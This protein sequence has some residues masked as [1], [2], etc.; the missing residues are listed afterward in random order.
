M[1]TVD[2]QWFLYKQFQIM[3]QKCTSVTMKGVWF[4]RGS[5][6][7]PSSKEEVAPHMGSASEQ[8]S[9]FC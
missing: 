7:P 5:Q 3:Q 1:L 8:V 9:I 6:A 4:P 2:N